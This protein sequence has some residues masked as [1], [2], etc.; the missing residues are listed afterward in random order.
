LDNA[1]SKA[2]LSR[3]LAGGAEEDLWGRRMRVLLQEMMLDLPGV[4]VAQLVGQ[5]DLIERLLQ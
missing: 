3:P 5:L 4:V 1:V 2:D